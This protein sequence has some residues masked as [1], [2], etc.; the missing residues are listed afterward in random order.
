MAALTLANLRSIVQAL[1]DDDTQAHWDATTELLFINMAQRD[2]LDEILRADENLLGQESSFTYPANTASVDITGASYLN[3][4]PKAILLVRQTPQSGAVSRSNVPWE[5]KPVRSMGELSDL[6]WGWGG[7]TAYYTNEYQRYYYLTGNTFHVGPIPTSAC[8]LKVTWVPQVTDL[9]A[10]GDVALGGLAEEHHQAVAFR[11][12]WLMN[13]K[14][15]GSNPM[16]QQL[17]Q[18][19]VDRIHGSSRIRQGARRVRVR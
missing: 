11:A 14:Q 6:Q 5:W 4:A 8:N 9:S 13:S 10:S 17:W 18:E 19:A 3:A 7:G 2:V 12:A 1:L 15:N 16:V